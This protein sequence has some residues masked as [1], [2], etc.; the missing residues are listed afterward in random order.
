MSFEWLSIVDRL[1]FVWSTL[2]LLSFCCCCSAPRRLPKYSQKLLFL[3]SF[4]PSPSLSPSLS[5][6]LSVYLSLLLP[7]LPFVRASPSSTPLLSLLSL[8]SVKAVQGGGVVV[9]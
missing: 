3:L 5:P 2:G 1:T 9:L 7:P 4:P 6:P 8:L